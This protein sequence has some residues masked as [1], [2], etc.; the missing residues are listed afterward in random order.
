MHRFHRNVGAR[1]AAEWMCTTPDQKRT[2][3]YARA[4]LVSGV[5]FETAGLDGWALGQL[6]C[7]SE[8]MPVSVGGL[9][10][11]EVSDLERPEVFARV[12]AR[13]WEPL[14]YVKGQGFFVHGRRVTR[15]R[16]LLLGPGLTAIRGCATTD[17]AS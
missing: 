2:W 10:P 5:S 12:P 17:T 1:G 7:M 11:V 14:L 9:L 13:G 8:P 16:W 6:R 3:C 4:F 15:A